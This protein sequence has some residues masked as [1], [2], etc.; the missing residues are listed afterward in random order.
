[1]PNQS[2]RQKNFARRFRLTPQPNGAIQNHN[3]LQQGYR[4][5]QFLDTKCTIGILR[6][7]CYSICVEKNVIAEFYA[8]RKRTIMAMC[9]MNRRTYVS[10]FV[11]Y[12]IYMAILTTIY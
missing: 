7:N 6:T 11:F 4:S 10:S 9:R 5:V 3:M 1:M 12:I 2:H 8:S